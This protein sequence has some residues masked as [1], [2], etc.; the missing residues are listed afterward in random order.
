MSKKQENRI[1]ELEAELAASKLENADYLQHIHDMQ[2]EYLETIKRL[3]KQ[4]N[5]ETK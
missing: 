2:R 5:G 3:R 4:L 1:T